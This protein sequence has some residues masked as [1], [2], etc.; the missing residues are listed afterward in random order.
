M[1]G[2]K[3]SHLQTV[4]AVCFSVNDVKNVL[5]NLLPL[6]IKPTQ[7]TSLNFSPTAG[8]TTGQITEA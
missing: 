3:E 2:S 5:V 7:K 1:M 4:A 6:K 8:Q